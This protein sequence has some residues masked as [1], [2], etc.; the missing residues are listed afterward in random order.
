MKHFFFLSI[1]Q[2]IHDTL[3]MDSFATVIHDHLEQYIVILINVLDLYC[4]VIIWR[5]KYK[6]KRISCLW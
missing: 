6:R 5:S 4:L 3:T 2:D 1:W